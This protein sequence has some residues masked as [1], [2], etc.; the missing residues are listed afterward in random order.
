MTSSFFNEID[1]YF[2]RDI[3]NLI[4]SYLTINIEQVKLNHKKCMAQ[5]KKYYYI[6]ENDI[7]DD[8]T[9]CWEWCTPEEKHE[10]EET[11]EE[12]CNTIFDKNYWC[13]LSVDD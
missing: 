3:N 4:I 5:H 13:N 11:E 7:F 10:P 12:Q 6:D 2:Y 8:D 1:K 9:T